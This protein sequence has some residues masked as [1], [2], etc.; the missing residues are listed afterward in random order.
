MIVTPVPAA[1]QSPVPGVFNPPPGC[2]GW[3]T[4]QS[5]GC[6]VSNHYKCE[7]DPAGDQWRAD[8]DQEGIFFV[9]HI[10]RETQ[11][12]ESYDMF[13]TVR[14]WLEPGA[15]D[16]ASFSELLSTGI[17][18]FDFNLSDDAGSKTNVKGFDKLTGNST[19]IDGVQLQETEFDFTETTSDGTVLR[20]ANGH[21]WIQPDWRL[22]FSGKSTWE[23]AEGDLPIDGTPMQFIMPGEKGF[24][25]T[26][27]I[28]DCDAITSSLP[29]VL[30]SAPLV[31]VG[32]EP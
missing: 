21:E 22:F 18:T 20:K 12:V 30:Q 16:P 7:A 24:F 27:P 32:A 31:R 5:R 13:P 11:W 9:S 14:Q 19:V 10:D 23:S 1:A 4:V 3:L 26:E 25:S 17:D 2:T 8:F 28:F 15:A 29:G 6:R